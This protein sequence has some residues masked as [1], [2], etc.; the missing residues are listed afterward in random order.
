MCSCF[1]C[2]PL[3]LALSYLC[4]LVLVLFLT[5]CCYPSL[6]FPFFLSFPFIF[7]FPFPI[8]CPSYPLCFALFPHLLVPLSQTVFACDSRAIPSLRIF[9]VLVHALTLMLVASYLSSVHY[10]ILNCS[11]PPSLVYSLLSLPFVSDMFS[12][13]FGCAL[14]FYWMYF[15][16]LW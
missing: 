3:L 8:P 10:F 1:G 14:P 12:L 9:C 13:S 4:F 11:L 15:P 7:S 5:I 16:T 6:M 2:F